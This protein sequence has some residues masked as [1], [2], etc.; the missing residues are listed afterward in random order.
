MKQFELAAFADEADASIDKQII[1]MK[2]EGISFLEIRGVDGTNISDITIEKAKEV[3][4]KLDDAG[5]GV[6]SLGSPF[7]KIGIEEDF[8]PH[9]DKFCHGLELAEALGTKHI[10]LF[11]FF[12]P[13]GKEPADYRSAV[14]ER[15]SQFVEKAKGSGIMLCHEN[16]KGIYGDIA[17]RCLEIHQ[18]VPELKAIFDP[19]N[20]IQCGQDTK[21]AWAMLSPYIEYMHI[22]DAKQDGFVVPAGEGVGNLPYL[23][24]E[25]TGKVLTLEPHLSVFDGLAGLEQEGE[26]SEINQFR[27]PNNRTAFAAAVSALKSLIK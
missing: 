11:S 20:F 14:M 8:A 18:A 19:A 22:K 27:Y 26:K 2:E 24:G 12:M 16:E 13:N 17:S 7:G 5:I 9:L 25:Y 4:K 23:L 1:A 3:R 21:E 15:L 6:W 10:R